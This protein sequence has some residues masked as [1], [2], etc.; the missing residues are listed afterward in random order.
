MVWDNL[1]VVSVDCG[2]FE[3]V[4]LL[5]SITKIIIIIHIYYNKNY[6]FHP[7]QSNAIIDY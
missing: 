3:E 1:M 2:C 5:N 4:S 6:S 7:R